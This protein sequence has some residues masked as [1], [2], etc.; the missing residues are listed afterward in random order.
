MADL[1]TFSELDYEHKR[2]KTHRDR[3]LERLDALVPWGR[4][5]QA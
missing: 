1:R 4:R 5:G 3:F 2:H